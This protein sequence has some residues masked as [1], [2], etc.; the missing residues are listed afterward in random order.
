LLHH[1]IFL[2]QAACVS[3]CI[4]LE[5]AL[6]ILTIRRKWILQAPEGMMIAVKIEPEV[7]GMLLK[8][9]FSFLIVR[10]A[11]WEAR[12]RCSAKWAESIRS[13]WQI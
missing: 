8:L 11:G 13:V 3:G 1:S 9:S 5:D 10:F 7:L 6:N 2:C 4:S 12:E